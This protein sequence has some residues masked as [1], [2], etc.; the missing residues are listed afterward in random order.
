[1]MMAHAE[2]LAVKAMTMREKLKPR[3][4]IHDARVVQFPVQCVGCGVL[5]ESRAQACPSCTDTQRIPVDLKR[6][7]S[8]R[9]H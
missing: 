2:A 3:E 7:K 9:K 6:Q 1:M 5:Y 8:S 4:W